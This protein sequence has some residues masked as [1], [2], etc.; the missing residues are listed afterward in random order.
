VQAVEAVIE[1]RKQEAVRV[2]EQLLR[3]PSISADPDRKNDV[4]KAAEFVA[5]Q[6]RDG[7]VETAEVIATDGHPIVY[8]EWLGAPDQPT[9]LVYGHYD[10]Q[11]V[12]DPA[13]WTSDPFEPVIRDGKIWARGSTDDKGQML[14]HVLAASAHL[15]AEGRLPVNVKFLIEGEEEV[16]S[17]NLGTF[18]QAERERLACD[19][20]VIS[21]TAMYAP[22]IPTLCVGLRGIAYVEFTLKGAATDL[23]SGQY[24]GAIDNPANA[25]A[26]LI[27]GLKDPETGRI[28]V[29]GFYDDVREVSEEERAPWRQLPGADEGFLAASGVPRLHGEEGWSVLE[30]VW[31]RPSLDVNGIWG[32]HVKPG[33]SMTVLPARASAKVSMRLV[34]DQDPKDVAQKLEKHLRAHLPPTVTLERFRDLH[35][36]SPWTT[37][38]DNAAVRAAFRAVEQGFGKSPL[39]TR[40][41]G[42]IP[43]VADFQEVLGAPVV[44]M[45][46][47]LPDERPHGPDEHFDLGNFHNGIRSAAWYLEEARKAGAE[48]R[49]TGAPS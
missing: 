34:P 20:V 45:G 2:L 49:G 43:I 15:E 27:A 46:F 35:G 23:H 18:L 5:G 44:L 32:G 39:P 1:K 8:G 7:G 31:V 24:G 13:E 30:R 6:L 9:V 41:G 25:L 36:G 38:P 42:S 14:A 33:E 29:D 12:V 16:G 26:R 11:P 4:R 40:E 3:I 28:L 19:A 21:D 10:V 47:G 22:G 17:A 48:L 37:S